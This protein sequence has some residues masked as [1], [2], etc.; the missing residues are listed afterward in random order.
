MNGVFVIDTAQTATERALAT[1]ALARVE[2]PH[3]VLVGGLGLGFTAH[4]VLG[5]PRVDRVVVAEIEDAVVGWLRDGTFLTAQPCWPTTGS[6]W[7]PRTSGR[8]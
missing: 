2:D 6:P 5:D 8:C 7:S 4:E 1:E 3:V